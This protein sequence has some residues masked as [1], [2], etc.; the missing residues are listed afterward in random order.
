[1]VEVPEHICAAAWELFV[2]YG[3][4]RFSL[5]DCTSF[6][7]MHSRNI[8]DAFTFDRADFLAAGF[9]VIPE[10]TELVPGWDGFARL[11]KRNHDAN[12]VASGRGP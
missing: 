5:T 1:V 4:R 7:T 11:G 10:N 6:A 3:E 12:I 9:K 8:F 2:R